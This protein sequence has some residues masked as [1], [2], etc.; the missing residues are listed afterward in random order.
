MEIRWRWGVSTIDRSQGQIE[1]PLRQ[2]SAGSRCRLWFTLA[3]LVICLMTWLVLLAI[4]GDFQRGPRTRTFGGDFALNI[5][6]AVILQHGGNPY[7]HNQTIATQQ[8][9]FARQGIETPPDNVTTR[10]LT[11]GGYPPLF[12]WL[13]QPLT[14]VPFQVIGV[15]WIISLY[16]LMALGFLSILHYLGWKRRLIPT[17]IFMAMP[18][19]TLEA[20]YGNPAALVFAV[21]AGSLFVQRR[22]PVWGGCLISLAWLKPQLAVPAMILIALFHVNDRRRFLQGVVVG[23]IALLAATFAAM[24]I[25]PM[26]QWVGEI[27]GVSAMVGE[28]PNMIPL[29][30]LYAG[31]VSATV[32]QLLQI[33]LLAVAVSLTAWSWVKLRPQG[34][35]PPLQVAW[36]WVVWVLALPYAHFREEILLSLPILALIGRDGALLYRRTGVLALYTVFAT[37]LLYSNQPFHVQ[38]LSLPLIALGIILYRARDVHEEAVPEPTDWHL[39]AGLSRWL[40]AGR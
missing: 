15:V 7:D 30:G 38:M 6:G 14:Y 2:R 25:E 21:I 4:G 37:V 29:V 17:L 35:V 18:Q 28:Q 24:G 5:T 40:P 3:P 34:A 9:F 11:W 26:V 12:F 20:F 39:P 16:G 27:R 23:S 32:R 19:T 22:H 13:L 36:L 1:T 8:S 31:A 33:G 10:L